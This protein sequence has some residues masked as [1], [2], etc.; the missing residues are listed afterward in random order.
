MSLHKFVGSFNSLSRRKQYIHRLGRI[1]YRNFQ[2]DVTAQH[3]HIKPKLV[4]GIMVLTLDSPNAKVIIQLFMYLEGVN[5]KDID[6]L[7]KKFGFPVGPATLADEVGID[8]GTH[9]GIDL[10]KTF[11]ERFAGMNVEAQK[12]FV[13]RG[14]LGVSGIGGAL[15]W[16]A[17]AVYIVLNSNLGSTHN[18]IGTFWILYQARP[19]K[20]GLKRR[21]CVSPFTVLFTAFNSQSHIQIISGYFRTLSSQ[22]ESARTIILM[23]S[24]ILAFISYYCSVGKFFSCIQNARLNMSFLSVMASS[25]GFAEY[26]SDNSKKYAPLSGIIQGVVSIHEDNPD[27]HAD[28]FVNFGIIYTFF[29]MGLWFA[30]PSIALM[31]CKTSLMLGSLFYMQDSINFMKRLREV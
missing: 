15:L 1:L 20:S 9:I 17:Q 4:D 16:T 11:G 12:E 13:A 22:Y 8:V 23:T 27:Y 25:M 6:K 28:G 30:P 19:L 26:L 31:G 5:P 21:C 14:F 24:S 29:I 2:D 3:K 10:S 7:M 18:G